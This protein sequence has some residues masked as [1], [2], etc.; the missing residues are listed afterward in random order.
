MFC[1]QLRLVPLLD[2]H[3]VLIV[4]GHSRLMNFRIIQLYAQIGMCN[5]MSV[6][7]CCPMLKLSRG[8]IKGSISS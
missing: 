1:F 8:I 6:E 7:K 5:V 3:H 2:L 4:R